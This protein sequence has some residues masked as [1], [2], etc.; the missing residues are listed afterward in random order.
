MV[1]KDHRNSLPFQPSLMSFCKQGLPGV[2][3]STAAL[4]EE[5]PSPWGEGAI[6]ADEGCE[7]VFLSAHH[8][9]SA[10]VPSLPK[11][12]G[13]FFDDGFCDFAFGY[14]QNDR[15]GGIQRRLKVFGLENPTQRK[16]VAMCIG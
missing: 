15:V 10:I 2:A 8:P 1:K 14:A 11:G 13:Y 6:R 5:K 4:C 7:K 3:E 12:E 9:P 16:S